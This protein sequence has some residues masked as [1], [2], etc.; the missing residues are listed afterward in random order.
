M[1]SV[2][3]IYWTFSSAAQSVSAFAALL[4]TGY[5]LVHNLMDSVRERDDT[6]DDIHAKLKLTY[7]QRLTWL[8]WLTGA[9]IVLSLF[10][11]YDNR[12]GDPTPDWLVG[13]TWFLNVAAIISGLAF[14]VSIVNPEKYQNAA[15]KVLAKEAPTPPPAA[16]TSSAE[17]FDA[18]LH[19]ERVIRDYLKRFDLYVP[20]RGAPR[21]SF[22]FRQM[23][24]AM[25][26]NERID[27][28]L[29]E[30]LLD[31]NK[32]RNLV[33]HGHVDRADPKMVARA[34]TAS[35]LIENL[36]GPTP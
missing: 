24:D 35:A 23:V 31:I 22:S 15:Q 28:T 30:E 33:F 2:D 12:P 13:L 14:V 18:F 29:Y 20:S 36:S 27:R 16:T 17:F 32:Y 3:Y 11:V 26:Q 34:R 8:A 25:L 9:A 10:V 4:L 1:Q 5:A 19:L 7:H 6:L 21:M